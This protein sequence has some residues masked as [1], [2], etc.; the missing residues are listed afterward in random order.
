MAAQK[1]A[2]VVT[3]PEKA[4]ANQPLVFHI[5]AENLGPGTAPKPHVKYT[6]SPVGGLDPEASGEA[7][8]ED[9]VA[10]KTTFEVDVTVTISTT[11]NTETILEIDGSAVATD[12]QN[13][14]IEDCSAPGGD[15]SGDAFQGSGSLTSG[16]YDDGTESQAAY[17]DGS[18][19]QTG[20]DYSYDASQGY[21][22]GGG[23]EEVAA[24]EYG[25]E[26][27]TGY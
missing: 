13:I 4:C 10:E 14:I 23:G 6:L 25:S 12:N 27:E 15:S 19:A 21:D 8:A 26:G 2:V 9:D 7:D 17:G 11:G 20:Y 18:G 1:W 3:K 24:S 5:K 22:L 16:G